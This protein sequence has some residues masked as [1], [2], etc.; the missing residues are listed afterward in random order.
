[1]PAAINSKTYNPDSEVKE[2]SSGSGLE[3]G[4]AGLMHRT[5]APLEPQVGPENPR[6]PLFYRQPK[7]SASGSRERIGP[8]SAD[9]ARTMAIGVRLSTEA[10]SEIAPAQ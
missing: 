3:P 7:G 6:T 5:D 9:S 2:N 4:L 8:S 1:M 10:T